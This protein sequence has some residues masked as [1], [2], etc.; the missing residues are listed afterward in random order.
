[1]EIMITSFLNLVNGDWLRRPAAWIRF[2][3]AINRRGTLN[4]WLVPDAATDGLHFRG[5]NCRCNRAR[6]NLIQL[7]HKLLVSVAGDFRRPSAVR[8]G[9]GTGDFKEVFRT[10][11][12]KIAAIEEYRTFPITGDPSTP[13]GRGAYEESGSAGSRRDNGALKVIYIWRILKTPTCIAR[14]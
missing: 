8:V 2:S 11:E 3:T 5:G 6:S 12:T 9:L 13:F 4:R 10:A 14:I 1:M 7:F